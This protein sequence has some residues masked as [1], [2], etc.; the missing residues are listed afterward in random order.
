MAKTIKLS[1]NLHISVKLYAY[2]NGL[3]VTEVVEGVLS[4]AR[5]VGFGTVLGDV[6]Q[7][8]PNAASQVDSATHIPIITNHTTGLDTTDDYVPHQYG[9]SPAFVDTNVFNNE[10]EDDIY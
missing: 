7:V 5:S 6:R 3:T 4:K 9:I 1:D 10:D 8:T 2:E